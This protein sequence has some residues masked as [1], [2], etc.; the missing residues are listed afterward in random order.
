MANKRRKFDPGYRKRKRQETEH[1]EREGEAHAAK[2]RH[3]LPGSSGRIPKKGYAIVFGYVGTGY[4]GMQKQL[5]SNKTESVRTIE[6]ELEKALY[7]AKGISAENFGC[8]PKVHWSRVARTDR[9]VHAACQLVALKLVLPDLQEGQDGKCDNEEQ[10]PHAKEDDDV[11]SRTD[12][13]GKAL[14]IPDNDDGLNSDNGGSTTPDKIHSGMEIPQYQLDKERAFIGQLQHELDELKTN[15]RVFG[16]YRV[17]KSFNARSM[18]AKRAYQY[19]IPI[20]Y[21]MPVRYKPEVVNHPGYKFYFDTTPEERSIELISIKETPPPYQC[22]VFHDSLNLS[23]QFFEPPQCT[24][25]DQVVMKQIMS[26]IHGLFQRYQGTHKFHNFTSR[27]D[28]SDANLWRFMEEFEMERRDVLGWDMIII[29]LK[30]QSFLLNQIRKMV[31]LAIEIIRGTAPEWAIEDALEKSNKRILHMAPGE[32]LLLDRVFYD[33]YNLKR[34]NPPATPHLSF[35]ELN[36]SMEEYK[37]KT[38]YETIVQN[39]SEGEGLLWRNWIRDIENHPYFN[40]NFPPKKQELKQKKQKEK[41]NESAQK[42][43]ADL[44]VL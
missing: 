17:T 37:V 28:P 6:G 12:L 14:T 40:E 32:G 21:L 2:R 24:K 38:I 15:I 7:K 18:C 3:N 31:G 22:T 1:D 19:L 34:A 41:D 9:G 25:M 35:I 27:V 39:Y 8:F 26:R 42:L 13:D 23:A 29:T 4:H 36:Q 10:I 11:S 5:D 43:N 30:G 20:K 16:M 44:C 33:S